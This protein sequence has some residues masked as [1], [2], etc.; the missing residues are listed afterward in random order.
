MSEKPKQ[1]TQTKLL[2]WILIVLM[3]ILGSMWLFWDVAH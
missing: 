3:L 2:W 1:D